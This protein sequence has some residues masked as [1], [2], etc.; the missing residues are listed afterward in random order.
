MSAGHYLFYIAV[1]LGNM[2]LAVEWAHYGI[3]ECTQRNR[4]FNLGMTINIIAIFVAAVSG[5]FPTNNTATL[6]VVVLTAAAYA[7]VSLT[8]PP[9]KRACNRGCKR[10]EYWYAKH[11]VSGKILESGQ[12]LREFGLVQK[13]EK[14][15]KTAIA[16]MQK[17]TTVSG[18]VDLALCH[19]WLGV[20]YRMMNSFGDAEHQF[21]VALSIL[22]K[23]CVA[24][25]DQARI[26]AARSH[27]IYR[28][29][30]LDHVGKRY[31]EAVQKYHRSLSMDESLG[32][33]ARAALLK[34]L[35]QQIETQTP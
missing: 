30:E 32:L 4:R 9:G 28:L 8:L 17:N 12:A 3:P 18:Q 26:E 5:H 14:L 1:S 15:M 20:L 21:T 27:V 13:T 19:E 22:D 6:V 11:H 33:H 34:H 35:L 24:N 16:E 25:A 7:V 10:I 31:K 23:L 2:M 29:G